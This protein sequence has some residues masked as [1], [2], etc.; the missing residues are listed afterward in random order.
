[1][2]SMRISY[3]NQKCASTHSFLTCRDGR[4]SD[5]FISDNPNLPELYLELYL[6]IHYHNWKTDDDVRVQKFKIVKI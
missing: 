4:W 2:L 3:T 1:M 6:N 5:C